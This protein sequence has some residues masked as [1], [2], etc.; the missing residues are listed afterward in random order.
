MSRYLGAV[1]LLLSAALSAGATD[2]P[3]L[4]P[5]G[6]FEGWK[7]TGNARVFSAGDL[8]GHINGGAELFLEFGFE[9]L[10]VQRYSRGREEL[11]VEVYRM[12][13]PIAAAGIYL[14]KCGN[15]IRHPG[16]APRHTVNPHQL[17]VLKHRHLVMVY[18]GSGAAQQVP[19]MVDF[20]RFVAD[21]L[22]ADVALEPLRL[23]PGRG[24][25]EG[26]ERLVRGQYGLQAI[27]V[28]GEGDILRL[29]GRVPAV[30]ANYKDAAEGAYTLILVE[31][32]DDAVARQ[33]FEHVV[34]NRDEYLE[35]LATPNNR[36]VMRDYAK[37][38]VVVEVSGRRLSVKANLDKHPLRR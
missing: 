5:D 1:I 3:L 30:S 8:Y 38:Y 34:K 21:K 23:L 15:E 28:L 6:H 35:V 17:M 11:I 25:V 37:K 24:L 10:T 4:P 12:R 13:D 16:F 7:R 14:M 20:G 29:G 31:Y 22:P 32:P 26:S 33:A 18:S 9:Q 19:T 36:I 27:Y 2:L